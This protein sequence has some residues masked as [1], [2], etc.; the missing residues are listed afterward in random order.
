MRHLLMPLAEKGGAHAT[1]FSHD[2]WNGHRPIT[3]LGEGELM[4]HVRGLITGAFVVAL[5]VIALPASPAAAVVLCYGQPVTLSGTGTI[6]GTSG[7]DV[8]L[9]SAEND[10][11]K[12]NGGND[13]ICGGDGDDVING[14]S[15]DDLLLGENG[16]D[17]LAGDA[18]V[19][20]LLG[21]I[22]SARAVNGPTDYYTCE[23]IDYGDDVLL[24]GSGGDYFLGDICGN[25]L[26]DGGPGSD[27]HI[28]VS[29]TA[30]GGSGNDGRVYAYNGFY[31][32]DDHSCIEARAEGGSGHD[33]EVYAYGGTA[34]G[35][36]GND[37][38]YGDLNGDVV[39]GSSGNDE[40]GD[41]N[42]DGNT[43]ALILNGGAGRDTCD[44]PSAN[45]TLIS[46]EVIV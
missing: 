46:C 6:N 39:L 34:D 28:E 27:I 12:G 2:P 3:R 40:L 11:I 21:D 32:C 29:G 17:R 7:P 22:D 42:F 10:V 43:E 23:G 45:D 4:N 37:G 41:Y 5:T 38:V 24:G 15:G 33:A 25:N 26:A 19:D 13:I 9:G 44:D 16:S 20:H 31:Y 14:N 1:P 35:G 30:K 36:S 8:I 18:G